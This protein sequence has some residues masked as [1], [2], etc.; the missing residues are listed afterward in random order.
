M[1][2]VEKNSFNV[3]SAI[4]HLRKEGTDLEFVVFPMIHVGEQGF[5]DEIGRR[6]SSCDLILAEGVNSRKA[7]LITFSYRI[8][9]RIQRMNLV[10]QQEG[11]EISRFREK[12]LNA[13]MQGSAFNERFTSLP[14]LL[15]LQL[16]VLVPFF[17]LYLML[18]GTRETIAEYIALEDLPSSEEIL[19]TDEQLEK[20]DSLL[21]DERDQILIS[22]IQ[23]VYE[24]GK[25]SKQTVGIVFGAVHVRAVVAFLMQRLQFRITKAEWVTVFEL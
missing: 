8:V 14:L 10:T 21:V 16:L 18:F 20:L 19:L 11:L 12:T 23:A 7:H 22:R 15:R 6:L 4:Y 2:F 17:A 24:S 5:F 9:R 3:R 25:T 13:D 1:Q